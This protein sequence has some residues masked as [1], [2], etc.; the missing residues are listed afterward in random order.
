MDDVHHSDPRE[1]SKGWRQEL[2]D[3]WLGLCLVGHYLCGVSFRSQSVMT[4]ATYLAISS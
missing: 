4:S 1:P 3:N 2:I